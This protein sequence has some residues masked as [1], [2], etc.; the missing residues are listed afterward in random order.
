MSFRTS[1]ARP[2]GLH[3]RRLWTLSAHFLPTYFVSASCPKGLLARRKIWGYTRTIW[4][5]KVI[6]M[7]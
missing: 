7:S 5:E 6:L 4:T 2:Y 3:P 1:I